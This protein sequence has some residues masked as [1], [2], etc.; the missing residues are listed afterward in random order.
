MGHNADADILLRSLYETAL[1]TRFVFG[2]KRRK[3]APKLPDIPRRFSAMDFRAMLYV[4]AVDI[5]LLKMLT[6]ARDV[7]GAKRNAR[8]RFKEVAE[9]VSQIEGVIG[10]DWV[11]SIWKANS[12][13]GTS[14]RGL[15]SWCGMEAYHIQVYG[16]QSTRAHGASATELVEGRFIDDLPK[17]IHLSGAML[18]YIIRD[19]RRGFRMEADVPTDNA[20]REF[21]A[22][23]DF[24]MD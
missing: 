4:A 24:N 3:T 10:K 7:V 16:L 5:S 22:A 6:Q 17:I 9:R 19:I 23:A 20:I 13:S 2:S 14:V 11:K 18:C 21:M 1:A 12:Y 15:A 8:Y